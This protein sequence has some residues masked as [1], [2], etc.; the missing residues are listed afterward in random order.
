MIKQILIKLIIVFGFLAIVS[1]LTDALTTDLNDREYCKS[2]LKCTNWKREFKR[3]Q[4]WC[5]Q[6][7]EDYR[8]DAFFTRFLKKLLGNG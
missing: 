4:R 5:N 2:R 7:N 1:N 6:G 3:C 8:L